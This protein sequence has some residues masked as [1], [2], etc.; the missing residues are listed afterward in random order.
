VIAP[1]RREMEKEDGVGLRKVAASC[2]KTKNEN[3]L[4]FLRNSSSKFQF[5]SGVEVLEF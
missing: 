2:K 4:P 3:P 5:G 1:K